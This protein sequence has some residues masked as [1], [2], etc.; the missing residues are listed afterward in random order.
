ME[1]SCHTVL[2]TMAKMLQIADPFPGSCRCCDII[3]SF[4]GGERVV[5][6]ESE[7]SSSKILDRTGGVRKFMLII[8]I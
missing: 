8:I 6:V 2:S 4:W 7:C 5:S 1:Y 3:M